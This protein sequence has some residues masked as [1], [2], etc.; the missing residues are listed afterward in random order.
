MRNAG[1]MDP[2]WEAP[3]GPELVAEGLPRGDRPGSFLF[4]A[5]GSA[6]YDYGECERCDM[7]LQAKLTSQDF[8]LRGKLVV[9]KRV[10]AGVCPRCGE[11]VVTAALERS[12]AQL[13]VKRRR[14]GQ[15]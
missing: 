10:P 13:R 6:R 2:M 4:C 7:P 8:W 9:V 3:L 14:H 11:K 5:H 12:L 1:S 15:R